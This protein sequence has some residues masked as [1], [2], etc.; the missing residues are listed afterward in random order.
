MAEHAP[1]T[2]PGVRFPPPLLFAAG[3]A[4]GWLM[5]RLRTFP[6]GG[7]RHAVQL[8]GVLLAVL[9]ASLAAWGIVTFRLSRTPIRPTRAASRLV[10]RGP[11]RHTRNPMYAGLTSAYLGIAAFMDSAWPLLALPVV[12][13]LLI[14]L[15]I[16]RE[17]A[18]LQAAFGDEYTSYRS[19]VRRWL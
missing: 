8:L 6:L 19:R 7:D 3:L 16:R 18:Y 9:G 11:Y 12:L 4:A 2:S 1:L 17:E 5:N 14:R 13:F 10:Q 15:V